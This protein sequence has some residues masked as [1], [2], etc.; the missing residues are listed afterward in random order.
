MPARRR[1][2]VG[3][4]DT[5]WLNMV[6]SNNLMV[7]DALRLLDGVPDWDEV[8]GQGPGRRDPQRPPGQGR[9]RSLSNAIGRSG[10]V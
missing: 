10:S 3:P 2:R 9:G 1:R 5:M 8:I 4:V 7:I 6:R